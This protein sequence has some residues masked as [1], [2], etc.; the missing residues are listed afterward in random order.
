MNSISSTSASLNS[1]S[2]AV[3]DSSQ[4]ISSGQRI[5]SAS[6]DA[7]G[8]AISES[9][10][11]QNRGQNQ[12]VRNLG[13]GISQLQTTSGGLSSLVEG[14]QRIR[15]LA[16]QSANGSY[17]DA[18]RELINKEVESISQQMTGQLQNTEFNGRA[19]FSSDTQA[20]Y[21]NGP[22]S[23]D[24][25]VVEPNGLAQRA[26]ELG[27]AEVS[28]G[29]QDQA[30]QAIELADSLISEFSRTGAEVGA[31]QNRFESNISQLEQASIDSAASQS[32][33]KDADI[34]KEASELSQN[35]IR[36]QVAI[37]VQAQA[38]Q[39]QGRVLQLLGS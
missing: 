7:A 21:Q 37:A 2:Q 33:I 20:V 24:S 11:S 9:L 30:Q 10:N 27:L 15:E 28:V 25:I 39:N 36:E 5:N 18:D 12:A 29:S 17:T 16:V 6:D 26:E 32:R 8:L 31:L 4:R 22:D 23:G 35:S 34:A 14:A 19:V 1:A 3:N 13:D 38:N